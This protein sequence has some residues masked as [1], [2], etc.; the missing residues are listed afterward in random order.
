MVKRLAAVGRGIDS[1]VGLGKSCHRHVH[2]VAILQTRRRESNTGNSPVKRLPPTRLGKSTASDALS[3]ALKMLLGIS[4]LAAK[5]GQLLKIHHL[6]AAIIPLEIEILHP[7]ETHLG[8][9]SSVTF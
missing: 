4:T 3:G 8:R 7:G 1:D 6:A 2:F 5:H 9:N